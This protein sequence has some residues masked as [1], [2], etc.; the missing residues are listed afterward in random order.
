M[1]AGLGPSDNSSEI[2][3]TRTVNL[4]SSHLMKCSGAEGGALEVDV[5]S[6]DCQHGHDTHDDF[7]CVYRLGQMD[8]SATIWAQV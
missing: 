6:S 2:S 1:I 5:C 3:F 4:L 7:I 8:A